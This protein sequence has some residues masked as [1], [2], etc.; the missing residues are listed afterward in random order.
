M[1]YEVITGYTGYA[2]IPAFIAPDIV[3]SRA[4]LDRGG[5]EVRS[6][7]I[8]PPPAGPDRGRYLPDGFETESGLGVVG[9]YLHSPL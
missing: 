9:G 3:P 8:G 7:R 4:L 5:S 2:A 1:L 6:S